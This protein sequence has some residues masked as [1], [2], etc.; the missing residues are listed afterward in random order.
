M[1]HVNLSDYSRYFSFLFSAFGLRIAFTYIYT[2]IACTNIVNINIFY[3]L[4]TF[5]GHIT[6]LS[7]NLPNG[8]FSQFGEK[9]AEWSKLRVTAFERQFNDQ[10]SDNRSFMPEAC[11]PRLIKK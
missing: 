3:N 5:G 6:L 4:K 1:F 11:N 10:D 9:L 7:L 2:W 8:N